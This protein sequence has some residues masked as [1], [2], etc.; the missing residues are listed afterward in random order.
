MQ[1]LLISSIK[2]S[3]FLKLLAWW[4]KKGIHY[5][6]DQRIILNESWN[7][8]Y[9]CI[10][11]KGSWDCVFFEID[12]RAQKYHFLNQFVSLVYLTVWENMNFF[13]T[14]KNS[15]NQLFCNFFNKNVAFTKFLLKNAKEEREISGCTK[16]PWN[17]LFL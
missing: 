5:Y 14:E 13:L 2:N 9:V 12:A 10:Y 7:T 15:W 11:R 1:Q 6:R 4:T 17:Q 16:I 8:E 3:T